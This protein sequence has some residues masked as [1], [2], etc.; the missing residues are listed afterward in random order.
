MFDGDGGGHDLRLNILLKQFFQWNNAPDGSEKDL[1]FERLFI[2]LADAELSMQK[3]KNTLIMNQ[4]ELVNYQELTRELDEKIEKSK[5]DILKVKEQLIQAKASRKNRM[6]YENIVEKIQEYPTRHETI[7]KLQKI[8]K[9]IRDFDLK[10]EEMMRKL[11][12]RKKQFEL[13]A[14]TAFEINQSLMDD[15]KE[16]NVSIDDDPM[17]TAEM[18]IAIL[19]EGP[20]EPPAHHPPDTPQ[21]TRTQPLYHEDEDLTDHQDNNH[22]SADTP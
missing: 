6:E 5:D 1:I 11:D 20:S 17:D 21:T 8:K 22:D 2:M 13:L 9:E 18:D 19:P 12:M 4:R 16:D 15:D 10:R 7:E 14:K 3:S